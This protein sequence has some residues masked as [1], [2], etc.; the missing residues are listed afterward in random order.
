MR[1]SASASQERGRREDEGSGP[2]VHFFGP[3]SSLR[4][5]DR[6]AVSALDPTNKHLEIST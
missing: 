1:S 3:L 5:R 4:I 2:G 6:M